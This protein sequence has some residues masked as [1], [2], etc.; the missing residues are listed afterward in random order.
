MLIKL[1]L[2]GLIAILLWVFGC[3][4]RP[5]SRNSA[6][7]HGLKALIACIGAYDTETLF[8]LMWAGVEQRELNC[9][10]P[11][12]TG[13]EGDIAA[14]TVWLSGRQVPRDLLTDIKP[15]WRKQ[16]F[17]WRSGSSQC[18][19]ATDAGDPISLLSVF[20]AQ[21]A[22]RTWHHGAPER[23]MELARMALD[24][25]PTEKA[26]ETLIRGIGGPRTWDEIV[27][28]TQMRQEIAEALPDYAVNYADWFET[29][30]A[31]RQWQS[32][33]QACEDLRQHVRSPL[34]GAAAA[35]R[36]RLAFYQGDY[37]AAYSD[38]R[39]EAE[40]LPRDA[41]VLTWLGLSAK[42]LGR[43]AEAEDILG[44]AIRYTGNGP[45][46]LGLYWNLGDCQ[47]AQGK[48]DHARQSYHRAIGYAPD[49]ASRL[50]HQD[51]L[52]QMQ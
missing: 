47:R 37:A 18:H 16:I 2:V 27:R 26:A 44:R 32:A 33:E 52:D 19:P 42:L 50:H 41:T 40:R 17:V 11:G 48:Y 46:L 14:V 8:L 30:V 22:A 31:N 3:G 15:T 5:F 13:G 20:L 49:E 34:E 39:A 51:L 4:L 29:M 35:C 45:A 12:V 25:R 6:R 1:R 21:L 38:L 23:A 28:I 43:Y 10:E 7:L 24:C 9:S 36:A